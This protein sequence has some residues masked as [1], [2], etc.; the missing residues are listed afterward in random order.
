[1][2]DAPPTLYVL[3]GFIGVGK[4]TFAK[5]LEQET[6]AIRFTPDEWM[7]DLYGTNPPKT[8]FTAYAKNVKK[9]MWK[10]IDRA[11]LAG[12][13]VILDWGFWKRAERDGVRKHAQELGAKVIIYNL[14]CSE[15]VMRKRVLERTALMPE[16]A[17]FIN[18]NALRILKKKWQAIDPKTEE[19]ILIDTTKNI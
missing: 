12:N 10:V 6:K 13:D 19:S 17:L 14:Q 4:T 7:V 11:L 2:T 16:G 9:V 8:K 15:E 18:D 1:M 5:K 3:C